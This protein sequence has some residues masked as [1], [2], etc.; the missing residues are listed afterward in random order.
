MPHA[1]ILEETTLPSRSASGLARGPP[2]ATCFS[3]QRKFILPY[4]MEIHQSHLF[5]CKPSLPP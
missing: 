2:Q 1:G 4:G 5:S 3:S